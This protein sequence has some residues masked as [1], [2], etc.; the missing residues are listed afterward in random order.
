MSLPILV[1]GL[2]LDVIIR[3]KRRWKEIMTGKRG[4][5][6]RRISEHQGDNVI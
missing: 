2:K 1:S 6:G 5:E 4:E 3:E